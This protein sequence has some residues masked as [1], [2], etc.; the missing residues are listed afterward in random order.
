L[1]ARNGGAVSGGRGISPTQRSFAMIDPIRGK[2]IRWTFDDGPM[3]GKTFEH[4]FGA[5]GHVQWRMVGDG[6]GKPSSAEHYEAVKV[7]SDVYAVSYLAS[8][9][10]TLTAVLDF[11]IGSV[12]G[13][14]SNEKQLTVQHGSFEAVGA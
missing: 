7:H 5:D 14:A 1:Q 3:A 8:S 4:T 13:F 2:T 9:G 12:V 6:S 11:R 10:Y